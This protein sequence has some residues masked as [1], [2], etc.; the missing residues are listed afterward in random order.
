MKYVL[1]IIITIS[2]AVVFY[3]F[4]TL[5][6]TDEIRERVQQEVKQNGYVD[7]S[8]VVGGDW[9]SVLIVTP[10]TDKAELKKKY[11]IAVNRISDFSIA[12]LDD[13]TLLVFCKGKRIQQYSYWFGRISLNGEESLHDLSQLKKNDTKFKTDNSESF[14]LIQVDE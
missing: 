7:F 2:A 12:Y 10:Y 8:K 14:T 5:H 6:E 13:R 4:Y 11:G 9:D 1:L 3:S